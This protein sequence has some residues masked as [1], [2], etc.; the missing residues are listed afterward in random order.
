MPSL[1]PF[2]N[3]SEI[4]QKGV[5]TDEVATISP[6]PTLEL[7][8]KGEAKGSVEVS[9]EEGE[10]VLEKVAIGSAHDTD[11]GIDMVN[12]FD[13]VLLMLFSADLGVE[14]EFEP[15]LF[16]RP[17]SPERSKVRRLLIPEVE[18]NGLSESSAESESKLWILCGRVESSRSASSSLEYGLPFVSWFLLSGQAVMCETTVGFEAACLACGP[19]PA[20]RKRSRGRRSVAARADVLFDVQYKNSLSKCVGFCSTVPSSHRQTLTN[21]ML[22]LNDGIESVAVQKLLD[23]G[24]AL[25]V[26]NH[27]FGPSF[28]VECRCITRVF[29]HGSVGW[30]LCG[31]VLVV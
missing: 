23:E 5:E 19:E 4:I 20:S 29:H 16:P 14:V 15:E 17:A 8:T 26:V 22:V 7:S 6:S 9:D 18:K 30:C 11:F 24:R 12:E 27:R 3:Y 28:S 31:S 21:S 10:G 2:R 1:L 13:R 25:I